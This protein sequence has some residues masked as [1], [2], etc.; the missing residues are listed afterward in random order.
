MNNV[1]CLVNEQRELNAVYLAPVV[2]AEEP[3]GATKEHKE[4]IKA[5]NKM[6]K[7]IRKTE[8]PPVSEPLL[9]NCELL[10]ALADEL[11]IDSTE[12]ARIDKMLHGNGDNLFL[13]ASIDNQF[14]FDDTV[15]D[16]DAMTVAFD[17]KGH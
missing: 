4:E 13:T 5:Y 11:E 17:Q 14:R 9:L 2:E 16:S 10:F 3:K 15:I 7:E 8:L 12:Q 6:L 1:N